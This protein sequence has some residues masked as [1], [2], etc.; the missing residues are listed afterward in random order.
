M[1]KTAQK[2]VHY[3]FLTVLYSFGTSVAGLILYSIV[4]SISNINF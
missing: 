2:F 1:K 4:L 3:A